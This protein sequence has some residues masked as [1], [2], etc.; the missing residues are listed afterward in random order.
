MNELYEDPELPFSD[1]GLSHMTYHTV[2]TNTTKDIYKPKNAKRNFFTTAGANSNK[3]TFYPKEYS[4][5]IKDLP[6]E[7]GYNYSIDHSNKTVVS[8]NKHN[9]STGHL[10]KEYT[11]P[12]KADLVDIEV[13]FSLDVVND[14]DE[15]RVPNIKDWL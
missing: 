13:Q 10:Y 2:V 4:Y 12:Y 15:P 9:Y 7:H 3:I 14:V 8:S 1:D 11:V 6:N 5:S